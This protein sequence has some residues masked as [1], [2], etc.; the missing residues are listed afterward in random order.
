MREK[1]GFFLNLYNVRVYDMA[2]TDTTG[3]MCECE[4]VIVSQ[5]LWLQR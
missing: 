1:V 3:V 2:K 5:M 4:F